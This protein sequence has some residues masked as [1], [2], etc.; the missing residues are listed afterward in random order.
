MEHHVANNTP[1]DGVDL[2]YVPPKHFSSPLS[3]LTNTRIWG[4]AEV[5]VT[6]IAASIPMLRV[7]IR[8]VAG[9]RRGY[10]AST[11]YY[12][13]GGQ[14]SSGKRNTR[15]VTI[16]SGRGPMSSDVEMA[17]HHTVINDDD[18][19]RGILDD[20]F[21]GRGEALKMGRI[22]QTQD[23]ELKYDTR[24]GGNGNGR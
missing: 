3:K 12:K 1:A 10:G 16:S 4:N 6:I 23:F 22:V 21:E 24:E 9:S 8:D 7:M 13:D 14:M 5:T 2:W 18:S 17:K 15:V 11:D 19:D 20:K